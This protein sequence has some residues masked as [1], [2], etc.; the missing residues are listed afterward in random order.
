MATTN[1]TNG[2]SGV[3]PL[4]LS[5]ADLAAMDIETALMAV[6]TQRAN[7]LESQLK[8][9]MQAVR[10][11][12]EQINALNDIL[13]KVRTVRPSGDSTKTANTSSGGSVQ[14]PITGTSNVIDQGALKEAQDELKRLEDLKAGKITTTTGGT[15]GSGYLTLPSNFK[16]TAVKGS[17]AEPYAKALSDFIDDRAKGNYGSGLTSHGAEVNG[18]LAYY[19]ANKALIDAKYSNPA[20]SVGFTANSDEGDMLA[21]FASNANLRTEYESY[22]RLAVQGGGT[23]AAPG[24]KIIDTSTPAPTTTTTTTTNIPSDIDAQIKAQQDKIKDLQA[25]KQVSG[26]TFTSKTLDQALAFYGFQS[27][28]LTQTQFDQLIQTI[29]SRI[30]GLNSTQQLDMLRLQSLTNKRNEAFDIMTN[31][32]KKMQDSRSSIVGNM[33]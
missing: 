33:R 10:E 18:F 31:F 4:G 20:F 15:A 1:G 13:A 16:P 6:Q 7:L 24:T 9:Q 8:D 14:V 11:R 19:S 17:T 26:T 27:G 22:L 2:S 25:G 23:A 3:N 21:A 28:N 5:A 30:D 32:I 12:N 29:S